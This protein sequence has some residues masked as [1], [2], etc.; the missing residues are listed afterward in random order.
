MYELVTTGRL[1]ITMNNIEIIVENPD[2]SVKNLI[3]AKSAD[4]GL[5][6]IGF[7]GDHLKHEGT[8]LF[9]GYDQIGTILF[10]NSYGMKNIE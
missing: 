9:M 8:E 3:N 5:T 4:A 6:I 2:T 7:R 1:P 10:V